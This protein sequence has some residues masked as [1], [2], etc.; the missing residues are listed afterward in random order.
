MALNSR[1]QVILQQELI[2]NLQKD[3]QL[4][5]CQ[6]GYIRLPV[7]PKMLY[8][9]PRDAL[10]YINQKGNR[11]YLKRDQKQKLQENKL[12]G[13]VATA[14]GVIPDDYDPNQIPE[15]VFRRIDR[16]LQLAQIMY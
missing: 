14:E 8:R 2:S 13:V 7:V 11:V 15:S 3:L 10:Y 9:G 1:E 5:Q 4:Q 12:L 16:N 6:Q